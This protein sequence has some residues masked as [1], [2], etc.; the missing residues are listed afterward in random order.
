[1][2]AVLANIFSIIYYNYDSSGLQIDCRARYT[3]RSNVEISPRL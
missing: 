1:M 2:T 3:E